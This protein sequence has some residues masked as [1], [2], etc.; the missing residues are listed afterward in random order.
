MIADR[1]LATLH[2]KPG[3]NSTVLAVALG[4]DAVILRAVRACGG[5]LSQQPR[6]AGLCTRH[7]DLLAGWRLRLLAHGLQRL[8]SIVIHAF[9]L[10]SMWS[11]FAA[12]REL[13]ALEQRMLMARRLGARGVD[14]PNWSSRGRGGCRF[15]PGKCGEYVA[16]DRI[17]ALFNVDGKFLRPRRHLPPPGRPARQRIFGRLHR[18]L[19]LARLSVR[20]DDRPAS[21]QPVAACIR[22]FR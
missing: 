22:R 15:A 3:G 1:M 6:A 17:V 19:P 13:N 5:Y 8:M 10:W 21:D 4:F 16:G 18:H 12:F 2:C 20:C 9:A 7:G 14:V 11:G